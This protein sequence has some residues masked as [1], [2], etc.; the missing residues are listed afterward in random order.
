M[1][2]PS[3]LV[4]L[5]LTLDCV[6]TTCCAIVYAAVGGICKNEYTLIELKKT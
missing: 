4:R 5:K 3:G 2:Q 1:F 6:A